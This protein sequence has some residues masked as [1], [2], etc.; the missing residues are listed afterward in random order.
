MKNLSAEQQQALD[1]AMKIMNIDVE[2]LLDPDDCGQQD[3][4]GCESRHAVARLIRD[5]PAH[6]LRLLAEAKPKF[7]DFAQRM[8]KLE[9]ERDAVFARKEALDGEVEKAY[10]DLHAELMKQPIVMLN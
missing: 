10:I 2:S 6:L 8:K 5:N 7:E 1:E 3:C 4:V 9:E